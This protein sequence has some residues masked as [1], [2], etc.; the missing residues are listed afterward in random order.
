[1]TTGTYHA[2]Y[3][4][5]QTSSI[6]KLRSFDRL[7]E[8]IISPNVYF[9]ETIEDGYVCLSNAQ[10]NIHAYGETFE[11]AVADLADNL[12]FAWH[13]YVLCDPS[14]FD[15][16]ALRYRAWLRNNIRGPSE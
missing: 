2:L 16:S 6:P 11:D 8:Y 12:D 9:E 4:T 15:D 3:R 13:E 10:A 5:N 14:D 7:G 1:M